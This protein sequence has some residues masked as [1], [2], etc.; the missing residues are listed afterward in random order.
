MCTQDSTTASYRQSISHGTFVSEAFGPRSHKS[1]SDGSCEMQGPA[2]RAPQSYSTLVGC[3][4]GIFGLAGRSFVESTIR[5]LT[6]EVKDC[7]CGG[8]RSSAVDAHD[9]NDS[10]M[11]RCVPSCTW[12]DAETTSLTKL[13][14]VGLG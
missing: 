11:T 8:N 10:E 3:A 12:N 13:R 6:N 14:P 7:S 2:G 4:A 9:V 1:V 5:C